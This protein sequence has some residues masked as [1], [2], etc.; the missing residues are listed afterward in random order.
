[1]L[2][3]NKDNNSK[4]PFRH[5]ISHLKQLSSKKLTED[6]IYKEGTKSGTANFYTIF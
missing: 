3:K 5:Q 4:S 6:K 2:N 1:M